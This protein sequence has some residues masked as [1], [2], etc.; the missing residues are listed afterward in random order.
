VVAAL[1]LSTAENTGAICGGPSV[2]THAVVEPLECSRLET[3]AEKLRSAVKN[4]NAQHTHPS[5]QSDADEL[6]LHG[7]RTAILKAKV[8]R[9]RSVPCYAPEWL[10]VD[11]PEFHEAKTSDVR[12]LM[13]V[14]DSKSCASLTAGGRFEVLIN[15]TV[16]RDSPGPPTLDEVLGLTTFQA[17]TEI[18]TGTNAGQGVVLP[19]RE[20]T[21]IGD[22]AAPVV[23]TAF[24]DLACEART[25]T[26]DPVEDLLNA[27]PTTLRIVFRNYVD[28][29]MRARPVDLLVRAALAAERQGKGDAFMA[30]VPGFPAYLFLDEKRLIDKARTLGLDPVRFES[31]LAMPTAAFVN[32]DGSK[33]RWASYT[34]AYQAFPGTQ[35]TNG[36]TA[37]R[38]LVAAARQGKLRSMRRWLIAH[39]DAIGTA[40]FD[41]VASGLGMDAERFRAD[42][43][44]DVT[45]AAIAEDVALAERIPTQGSIQYP[46]LYVQGRRVP[47]EWPIDLYPDLVPELAGR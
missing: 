11:K 21:S 42:F 26:S 33:G 17:R 40:R 10:R 28:R 23:V 5:T 31:D 29:G 46:G 12:E 38:A 41:D 44:S 8:I 13:Y 14:D 30:R 34:R 3:R 32:E 20:W 24:A 43:S 9:L 37:A 35:S 7:G 16:C 36:V 2:C 4:W 6:L 19:D 39:C 22:P 47:P 25:D 27:Y 45:L 1:V 15:D 18:S